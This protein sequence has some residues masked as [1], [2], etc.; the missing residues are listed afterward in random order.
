MISGFPIGRH[1]K[2]FQL[3]VSIDFAQLGYLNLANLIEGCPTSSI[4]V[5]ARSTSPA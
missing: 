2:A 4:I 3:R 1:Q 5:S